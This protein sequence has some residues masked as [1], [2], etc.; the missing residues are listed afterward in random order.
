MSRDD[1]QLTPENRQATDAAK[2][3]RT[4]ALEALGD[5]LHD[6]EALNLA[7]VVLNAQRLV[8][9]EVISSLLNILLDLTTQAA[10]RLEALLAAERS[11]P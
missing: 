3:S 7:V 6:L 5:F 11:E 4:M 8:A 2:D 1:G 9:P 10:Q